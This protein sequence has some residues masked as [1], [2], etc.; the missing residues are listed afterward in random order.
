V[1]TSTFSYFN[2]VNKFAVR[3]RVQQTASSPMWVR[4]RPLNTSIVS[5][6]W[7]NISTGAIGSESWIGTP[8]I[9]S[10]G[11]GW[12]RLNGSLDMTGVDV[13]GI[14][15]IEFGSANGVATI[16]RNGENKIDIYDL[17]ITRTS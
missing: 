8:T 3:L 12:Y 5:E 14:L 16:L 1:R 10:L 4:L 15:A 2:G 17:R 11:G 7:F 9:T 6:A 13:S